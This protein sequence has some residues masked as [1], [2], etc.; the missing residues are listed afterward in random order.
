MELHLEELVL[1]R[2][3]ADAAFFQP[4]TKEQLTTILDDGRRLHRWFKRHRAIHRCI[5]LIVVLLLLSGDF[6]VLLR[7]PGILFDALGAEPVSQLLISLLV[8]AIHS[9][10][11]YSIVVFSLHEGAAHDLIFPSSGRGRSVLGLIANN[12]CRLGSADPI[13]YARNHRSHHAQFGTEG[14]GEFL[15]F[16][17]RRRYWLTFLPFAMFINY[18]DFVVHRKS[19]HTASEFVSLGIALAYNVV[20]GRAMMA[21]Y[22][23]PFAILVLAIVFPHVGFYIDRARQFT[24][25]NLMPLENKDG[26]RSFGLGFWGL[27]IGGGPWGQ[28]CHWSHHLVP[29][30]PWYQQLVLHR[31]I[32]RL[33]TPIQREQYLIEPLIG[34]PRLFARLWSEPTRFA[35]MFGDDEVRR[36]VDRSPESIGDSR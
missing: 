14:D 8:G 17:L 28:P 13:W 36:Q 22:G 7:V 31:R 4:L 3:F 23:L 26:S 30:I 29:S 2:R 19:R 6:Y 15:N 32:V 25:H 27:L 12:L 21:L 33:L 11:I 10:I 5:N 9:W 35:R 18:S 20:Y 1:A 16:V 34:F 24:E